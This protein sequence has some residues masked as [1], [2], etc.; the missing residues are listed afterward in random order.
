MTS[1]TL[2]L[3]REKLIQKLHEHG[4]PEADLERRADEL[5]APIVAAQEIVEARR[6]RAMRRM[7]A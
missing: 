4:V 6:Q 7:R 1:S 5:M 2:F 3:W